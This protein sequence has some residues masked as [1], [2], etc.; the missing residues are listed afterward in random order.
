MA[1]EIENSRE[2]SL[3][4]LKVEKER[5]KPKTKK[6]HTIFLGPTAQIINVRVPRNASAP[7]GGMIRSNNTELITAQLKK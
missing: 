6:E 7:H 3:I 5:R 4:F 1:A 2:F